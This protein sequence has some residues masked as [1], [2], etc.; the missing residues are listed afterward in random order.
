MI[1]SHDNAKWVSVRELLTLLKD[2]DVWTMDTKY[3][4]IYLDTRF[5]SGDW[6][7]TIR[8]RENTKY[9]SLE[10]LKEIRRPFNDFKK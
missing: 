8:D 7:C 3:L 10:E 9:L 1:E 5:I 6:H 2:M 4:H